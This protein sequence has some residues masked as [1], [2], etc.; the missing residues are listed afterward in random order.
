[1]SK[2]SELLKKYSPILGSALDI[3]LPGS[4]LIIAGI[5]HLFGAN[6]TSEDDI[7]SK[8]NADPEAQLKLLQFQQDHIKDI[9]ELV[10]KDRQSAREREIALTQ[11]LGKRDFVLTF[12]SIGVLL[13]F[14]VLMGL[15]CFVN[16]DVDVKDTVYMLAGQMSSAVMLVLSYY[17]GSSKNTG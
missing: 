11:T 9:F 15:L 12:L 7:I 16:I 4:S 14:F 2:L 1:M 17:Y 3:A 10:I 6:S 8:I 13:G 5:A